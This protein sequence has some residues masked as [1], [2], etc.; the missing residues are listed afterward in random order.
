[1]WPSRPKGIETGL[2]NPSA[3]RIFDRGGVGA[4]ALD[5]HYDSPR[6]VRRVFQML[7]KRI[8]LLFPPIQCAI[9]LKACRVV[10][11]GLVGFVIETCMRQLEVTGSGTAARALG[12]FK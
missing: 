9:A 1:M 8:I 5:I 3:G 11:V 4:I 7:D 10:W 12:G 2:G 6:A